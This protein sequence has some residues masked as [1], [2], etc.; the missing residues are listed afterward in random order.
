MNGYI[1][2]LPLP[3]HVDK[4]RIINAINPIKDIDGFHKINQDK[5]RI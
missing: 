3:E 1:V 5:V 4:N 2:Q